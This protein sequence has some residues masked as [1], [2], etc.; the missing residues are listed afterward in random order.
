MTKLTET[1]NLKDPDNS[2]A[3]LLAAHEGL[4]NDESQA[5]NAR[6]I[7]VLINHIGDEAV[8]AE[9]LEAAK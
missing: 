7:L 6:L 3:N 2:Y 1:A 5:F 8:L 9:A 4:S